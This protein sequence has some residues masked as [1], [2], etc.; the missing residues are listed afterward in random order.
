MT[1]TAAIL[2]VLIASLTVVGYLL[3]GY[4]KRVRPLSDARI[5]ERLHGT[6]REKI[7]EYGGEPTGVG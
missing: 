5:R 1:T 3:Q 2:I 7:D 4:R 6:R